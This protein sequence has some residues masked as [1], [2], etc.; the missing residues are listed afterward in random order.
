MRDTVSSVTMLRRGKGLKGDRLQL[1]LRF[2][3]KLQHM[4]LHNHLTHR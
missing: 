2:R 4:Q 1:V 3:V